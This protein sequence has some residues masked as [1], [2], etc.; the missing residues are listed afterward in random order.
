MN[1]HVFIING[2]GGVGKDTFVNFVSHIVPTKN[3]SSVDPIKTLAKGIGWRGSK[4]ERDRKFLSD[5][6]DLVTEYND[7]PMEYLKVQHMIFMDN[8]QEQIM[9]I[10][11]REPKEIKRAVELFSAKTVLISNCNVEGI[12]SNHA[13]KNVYDYDYD[14]HIHND[15]SLDML[16]EMASMFC[17]VQ[18]SSHLN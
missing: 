3:V 18:L 11:I 6:K 4:E 10:H 16:K 1:K 14:I 15:G 2:S 13:D 5:L 9:F 17:E 8:D 12:S 7:Y